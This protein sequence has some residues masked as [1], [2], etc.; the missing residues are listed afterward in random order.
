[1]IDIE[2]VLSAYKLPRRVFPVLVDPNLQARWVELELAASAARKA[3]DKSN[4][5]KLHLEAAR[6]QAEL[7]NLDSEIDEARQLWTCQA[8]P[9][10]EWTALIDAHPPTVENRKDNLDFNPETLG[11]E[12]LSKSM[13]DPAMTGAQAQQ[14]WDTWDSAIVTKIFTECYQVN[15]EVRDI[16]FGSSSTGRTPRSGQ[17]ST[18]APPAE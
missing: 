12:L 6:I 4:D 1:M 5:R 7:E 14:L 13:V 3:A 2:G 15:R 16:P 8:L 10:A 11:P 17:S 9:K 18:T